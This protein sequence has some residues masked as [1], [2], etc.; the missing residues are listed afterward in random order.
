MIVFEHDWP[1]YLIG[2]HVEKDMMMYMFQNGIMKLN[3]LLFDEL[4]KEGKHTH[5][6]YNRSHVILRCC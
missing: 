2:E 5:V 6:T 1:R 4:F 3:D